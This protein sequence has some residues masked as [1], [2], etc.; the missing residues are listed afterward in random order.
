MPRILRHYP[1][2]QLVL[3]L[4]LVLVLVSFPV[5]QNRV[6]K[7]SSSLSQASLSGATK[8]AAQPHHSQP[9][10]P[11][12]SKQTS[13]ADLP[14]ASAKAKEAYG[15]LP[16]SFEAN[17]GQSSRKVNFLA[18]GQ[19]YGLF[20]TA[21]G[22][23]MSLTKSSEKKTGSKK[24][25]AEGNSSAAETAVVSWE[26]AAANKSP[27]ISGVDALP[28]KTNYF[29][30]DDPSKWQSNISTY[31]KVR[32]SNVYPGIDVVYYGNQRQL[33]YD[34][35]VAPG[36]DP[37]RIKLNFKGATATELDAEG[38]LILRTRAG[39]ITQAKP[40]AY[41]EIAGVRREVSA[42]YQLAKGVISFNLGDYDSS[43]PLV[44]DPVFV[45]SSFLGG[46]SGENGLAIAA[47]ANGSAY[48]TGTTNSTD[49]PTVGAMQTARSTAP[50][51]FIVK[52]SPNGT[53]LVYSTYLG[54]NSSDTARAIAVDSQGNAYVAGTTF[55]TNFPT[56]VGS[57]QSSKDSLGD[58]F[59]TK[60]NPAGSALI[61]S[62]YLG[63]DDDENIFG[64]AVTPNGGA[65]VAGVTFSSRFTASTFPTPRGGSP[66]YKTIDHANNWAPSSAGLGAHSV[67][68]FAI[69]TGNS[70]NIY[71]ATD[72]GLY[73]SVD[74]G[75]NWSRLGNGISAEPTHGVVIDP[76]NSSVVYAATDSGVYKSTNGGALFVQKSAGILAG[77]VD[78]LAID[79]TTPATLYAG[80]GVGLFK[81]TNGG[82]TWSEVVYGP[83]IGSPVVTEIV[84]DPTN[85]TVVYVGTA[86]N[87]LFKTTSGNGWMSLNNGLLSAN[88]AITAVAVDPL[89][90][91][92]LYAAQAD[93]PNLL[94]T[95]NGGAMWTDASV[96]YTVG[97]AKTYVQVNSLAIDPTSPNTLYAAT[98][99]GGLFKSTDGGANWTQSNSGLPRLYQNVVAIDPN[100]PATLFVGA[101]VA[102]DS[103][104]ARLNPAGSGLDYLRNFGGSG[105]DYAY[106]IALDAG[107]N[108]YVAGGTGS[109]DFPLVH[110]MQ[111]TP[112]TYGDAFVAKF[113]NSGN[114]VYSTFLGGNSL[115][116]ANGIAVRDGSAYVVGQTYSSDFPLVN[117]LK[118][119]LAQGDTDAFVA[120]FDG[121]GSALVF[122]TYLGGSSEDLATGVAVGLLGS[123]FITGS[124]TSSDFPVLAGAQ[125]TNGGGRDAFVTQLTPDGNQLIY[126]TYLGGSASD[127]ANGIAVD[128]FAS[129]YVTGVTSSN[130]FPTL[131]AFQGARKGNDAFFT[132]IGSA[133]SLAS[134]I[135]FSQSSYQ[136]DEAGFHV[137]VVVTRTGSTSGTA[138]VS[139]ATS[140]SA[141]GNCSNKT[142]FASSKCDYE[143]S[144]GALLFAGGETSKTISI[145]II[146]DSYAEGNET[147]N[148]SLSSPTN[149]SLGS[150]ATATITIGD[151]ASTDGPDP[152]DQS[153][154]FV[155]QHYLDFL[156]RE[157]DS[158]GLNFWTG[159]INNCTP[160]PQCTEVKRI[161]VSAAFFLSIEF[162]ETGYL[163]ERIY[164][165]AYGDASGTSNL[166]STHQ[167]SVPIIRLNEFLPDSQQ[168]G[169]GVVVGQTGW[170]QVLENNKVAYTLQFVQHSRFSTS[171]S[172]LLTP[173]QFVDQLFAHAGVTPT[174][175]ERNAAINE[176]G[177]AATSND[178]AARA[179][180]LRLVA[181]NSTL[182]LN[183][184]NKA[185]VLMQFFGYLRRN[186]NDPQDTDYTGYDFWLTKLNEFNGDFIRAEMVKAF[187]D[188]N[189]YRAR[190]GP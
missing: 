159:E 120:K 179:R 47:D 61:Y 92:V 94:K 167:L 125:N 135:Q 162:Q 65:T 77:F 143:A 188:S 36:K 146:D 62:T 27:R 91:A 25:L 126:S 45:Y 57:L 144:F 173:A 130:N 105:E 96:T 24:N 30:G 85:H 26:L 148:I 132:K 187:L 67:E 98:F 109:T 180:A 3:V 63:G 58:G 181:E 88:A 52:V 174:T 185:F 112:T 170:E 29:R 100:N 38:N 99:A 106:A 10:V 111:S 87:G 70:N 177:G 139:Y 165:V 9:V 127:Q 145:P 176:F 163:V 178:N 51:S 154:F 123:A 147:F 82:D 114:F 131:N 22:P 74:A 110:A 39:D 161:N 141:T 11:A 49:F 37:K 79:P 150:P 138:T 140:D 78:V 189:E 182:K 156:N 32:Y 117:P 80:N 133:S 142:G 72:A 169:R 104:V 168:I 71:A 129:A 56:T 18:R 128:S 137:D 19:G 101:I 15:V 13:G 73:K 152:I 93:V 21:T 14:N 2:I 113:D 160:K 7:T 84:I 16:L 158:S 190:F 90:P 31:A 118:S 95:T 97:G 54:G 1:S 75:V 41:Q 66:A 149:A 107:D 68:G 157:P 53:A 44:I 34:F 171:Y 121:S 59:V 183:E 81:T 5:A 136:V 86:S 83:N 89:N 119:V 184:K 108:A 23:V 102:A 28:G 69:E 164:K 4:S 17:S 46:V 35:I 134:N 12:G 115:D 116:T 175:A 20:L 64:L 122:S 55:S 103:F 155:R 186:P 60:I 76:S 151:I 43:R 166:G 8:N 6:V 124:T 40:F 42:S 172:A 33:E 50:D 48:I 153:E